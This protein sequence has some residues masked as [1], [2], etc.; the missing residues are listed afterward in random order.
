MTK[1]KTRKVKVAVPGVGDEVIIR[2]VDSGFMVFRDGAENK[3]LHL[4]ELTV[5]GVVVYRDEHKTVVASEYPDCLSDTENML[6]NVVLNKA[7]IKCDVKGK[8]K[9]PSHC[10]ING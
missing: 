8:L 1:R 10:C 3:D 5:H 2:W 4:K 9:G 6:R 7:I